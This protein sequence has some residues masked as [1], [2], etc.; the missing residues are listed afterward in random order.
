MYEMELKYCQFV[1]IELR[2]NLD[3]KFF[4]RESLL[5]AVSKQFNLNMFAQ[6]M[7]VAVFRSQRSSRWNS[8]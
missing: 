2:K 4:L 6:G 5:L 3:A 7:Y 1:G 8:P